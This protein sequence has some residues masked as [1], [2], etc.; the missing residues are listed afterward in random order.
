MP[1]SHTSRVRG[2]RRDRLLATCEPSRDVRAESTDPGENDGRGDE[3][4]PVAFGEEWPMPFVPRI[5]HPVVDYE[6]GGTISTRFGYGDDH[7]TTP[8]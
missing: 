5:A 4:R 8:D 2:A 3:A 6:Y 7:L 1:G